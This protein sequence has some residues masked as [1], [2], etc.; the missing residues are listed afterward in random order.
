MAL[1]VNFHELLLIYII[2]C[3]ILLLKSSLHQCHMLQ[4]SL[5]TLRA[6]N[7]HL[8]PSA[9]QIAFYLGQV[10]HGKYSSDGVLKNNQDDTEIWKY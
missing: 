10:P 7:K 2:C 9:N 4:L 1:D 5:F 8:F 6:M 3:G